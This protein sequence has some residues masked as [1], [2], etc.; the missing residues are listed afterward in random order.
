M[1]FLVISCDVQNHTFYWENGNIKSISRYKNERLQGKSE[2][3]NQNGYLIEETRYRKNL[4]NG[5]QV[6]YYEN[7]GKKEVSSFKDGKLINRNVYVYYPNGQLM[8]KVETDSLYRYNGTFISFYSNGKINYKGNYA[9]CTGIKVSYL[10][11]ISRGDSITFINSLKPTEVGLWKKYYKN[12]KLE[13]SGS[14]EPRYLEYNGLNLNV[15]SNYIQS[16]FV[17]LLPIKNGT[18]NQFDSTGNLITKETW[19]RGT[20][21]P[22]K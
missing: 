11:S 9:L 13:E 1:P 19:V 15:N 6:L 12:G 17:L 5:K 10:D 14:Y 22:Q 2:V 8:Y 3:Y 21:I 18:W 20:L 4:I 16:Q 7:V